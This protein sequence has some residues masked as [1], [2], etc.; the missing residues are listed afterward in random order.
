MSN[1][2]VKDKIKLPK[3]TYLGKREYN[4]LMVGGLPVYSSVAQIFLE[5]KYP[6]RKGCHDSIALIP[7]G[8][9]RNEI[10]DN[11]TDEQAAKI[12]A[13][14]GWLVK[15]FNHPKYTRCPYCRTKLKKQTNE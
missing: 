3:N 5:C 12:F 14:A 2:K 10:I 11:I 7:T 13:D 9:H 4:G 15:G 6:N 8:T 1:S